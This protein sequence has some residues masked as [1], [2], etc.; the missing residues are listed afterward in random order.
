MS[1][2]GE[3]WMRWR[4]RAG[5]PVGLLYAW[6]ADPVPVWI[7]VGGAIA[8]LGLVIRGAAAGHLRK[9]EALATSG[10]YAFTRNPLYFGSA[11]IAA[12]FLVAGRS[13][14]AAGVVLA[15]FVLFY[16]LVMRREEGELQGHHIHL[17]HSSNSARTTPSAAWYSRLRR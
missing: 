4:V 14:I 8:L 6:L 2:A 5:Y 1:A 15:Y 3:M 17:A 9:H 10:P 12:G 13:W 7:T 16:G 11:L